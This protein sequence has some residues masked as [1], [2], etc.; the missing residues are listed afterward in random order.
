MSKLIVIGIDGGT[1]D[2]MLSLMDQGMLPNFEAIR[3]RGAFGELLSVPNQRSAAAW[4]SF[5]T[6]TNPGRH[7]IFEFYERIPGSHSVRFTRASQRNG[8]SFWKYLSDRGKTVISINVPMSYPAEEISGCVISGLDA[9]GKQSSGFTYPPDLLSDIEAAVGPYVQE[10]GVTSLV[11]AGQIGEALDKIIYSVRQRGKAVRYLMGRYNW[12]TA[13]AVFRETD[14]VQH[15][16][17]KY[18]DDDGAEFKDAVFKVYQ[19]IDLEVGRILTEAGPDARVLVLSDHGFGPRQHGNGCLNQWLGEAGFLKMTNGRKGISIPGIL[20]KAY[21]LLEKNLSRRMKERLF[22]M[23]PGVISRVHSRVFF[24]SIDWEGTLAYSDNIMP[25]VWINSDAKGGSM[26]PEKYREAVSAVKEALLN[27]CCEGKTGKKVVEWVK[28][29]DEIYSGPGVSKAPDLL[30]KW[31]ESEVITGL[32][33]GE[34]GSPIRPRY[35]TGEFAVISGDH[36]PMGVFMASGD[37]IRQNVVLTGLT[38][39]DVTA[40]AVYLSDLPVPEFMEG[41]VPASLFEESFLSSHRI[42]LEKWDSH[43]DTADL[44]AYSPQEEEDLKNRLRGLGYLE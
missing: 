18:L 27:M 15:C 21:H 13:I 23:F 9:P 40:T 41:S 30:I 38:I 5:I 12:D 8:I 44:P 34:H 29:R 17:W 20:R 28:H 11:I 35:P 3:R 7:G 14:P 22:G 2:I 6:G 19:E 16:F 25:V 4:S 37:G 26:S 24:G 32:R 1:P 10:P 39:V 36:R 43:A 42:G 33:F 31:K